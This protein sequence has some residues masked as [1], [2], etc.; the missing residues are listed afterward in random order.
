MRVREREKKVVGEN[1]TE[2]R[3]NNPR[4]Y[5]KV[6]EREDERESQRERMRM[7]ERYVQRE[8]VEEHIN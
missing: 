7:T 2:W 6:R 5:K 1:V 4:M 8:R 3:D